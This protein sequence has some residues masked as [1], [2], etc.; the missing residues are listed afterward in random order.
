MKFVRLPLAA[1]AALCAMSLSAFAGPGHD[2]P[3]VQRAGPPEGRSG[4]LAADV[5]GRWRRLPARDLVTDATAT[6]TSVSTARSVA[7]R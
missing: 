6:S 1:A 4:L 3:A 7:C 5:A 2:H